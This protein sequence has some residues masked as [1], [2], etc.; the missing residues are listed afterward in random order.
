V[1][2]ATLAVWTHAL[3]GVSLAGKFPMR[4]N[5]PVDIADAI[6]IGMQWAGLPPVRNA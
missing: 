4:G 3:A 2:S 1:E 5:S 6:P